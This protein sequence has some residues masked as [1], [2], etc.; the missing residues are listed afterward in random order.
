[1]SQRSEEIKKTYHLGLHEEG[2][3]FSEVYTASFAH[4][5]RA[6]AGSIYYL[7]EKGEHSRLH[8]IDCDEIWYYHEGC[9]MKITALSG[10]EKREYLLGGDL[11]RGERAI[12]VVPAGC[13]FA[14]ENLDPDG[15]TFVSCL[16]VPKFS[17]DGYLLVD[18]AALRKDY[19]Q[20]Y[21]ELAHL[22]W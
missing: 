16:T 18:K 22:A 19:P 5:G 12:V 21:E 13:V 6:M 1:M 14:A 10:G 8:R 15:F 7:L 2:G 3:S 20:F 11:S 9:G 17:H 4:D